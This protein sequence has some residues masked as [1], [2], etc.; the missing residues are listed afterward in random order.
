MSTRNKLNEVAAD[1]LVRSA[2]LARALWMLLDTNTAEEERDREAMA[3]L[4]LA[5][6]VHA[7]AALAAFNGEEGS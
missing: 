5:V 1:H 7:S 4:A 2:R 3:E 6:S